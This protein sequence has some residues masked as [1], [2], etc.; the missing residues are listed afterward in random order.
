MLKF[1]VYGMSCAACSARVQKAVSS[2]KGVNDCNVNLLTNS[3]QVIGNAEINEIILAVEKA[4]YKAKFTDGAPYK[5]IKN[6]DV[7]SLLIRVIVSAVFLIGL[8]TVSMLIKSDNY[9]FLALLQLLIT[10]FIILINKK[11]FIS[12]IE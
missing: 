3:M 5:A 8:M 2:V 12:F 7:R 9:V 10:A 11:F 4:G 6:Q 1:D